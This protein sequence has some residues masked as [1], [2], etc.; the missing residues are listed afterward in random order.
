[1]KFNNA[2]REEAVNNA[3]HHRVQESSRETLRR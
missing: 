2:G 1:M 3:N